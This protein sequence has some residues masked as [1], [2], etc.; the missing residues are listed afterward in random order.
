MIAK[1]QTKV[2]IILH[3]WGHSEVE[4]NNAIALAKTP[5]CS[6]SKAMAVLHKI[7]KLVKNGVLMIIHIY[8]KVSIIKV[9]YKQKQSVLQ[10]KRD[11][12]LQR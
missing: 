11:S 12:H 2:L 9:P 10:H 5:V 7:V 8:A 4:E 1:K 6:H 3:G